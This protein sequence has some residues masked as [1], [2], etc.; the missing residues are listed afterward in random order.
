MHTLQ[1]HF[2]PTRRLRALGGVSFSRAAVP[3]VP[4]RVRTFI[5][6]QNLYQAARRQFGYA[7]PNY[8]PL[9]LSRAVTSLIPDRILLQVHF[10]TGVHRDTG[11]FGDMRLIGE[12]YKPDLVMIPIGGTFLM[13][14]RDAA[15][16]TREMLKPKFAIPFHYGTLPVLRGTPAEYQAAL[17][18]APT[19]IFPISPGDKLTF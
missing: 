3:P 8:D 2:T 14:P 15:Y 5:D 11:L 6:G 13:D 18:Q 19:Q 1:A 12:Y 9:K 7:Q 10:Y 16:A 17:G 4:F